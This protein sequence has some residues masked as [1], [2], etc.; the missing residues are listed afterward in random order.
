MTEEKH[1]LLGGAWRISRV[2]VA[3]LALRCAGLPGMCVAHTGRGRE[4]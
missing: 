4:V 2:P 3:A 1:S